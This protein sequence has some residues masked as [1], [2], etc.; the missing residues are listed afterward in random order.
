MSLLTREQVADRLK[1]SPK[2]VTRYYQDGKIPQPVYL[3]YED[4]RSCRWVESEL[5]EYFESL[6][7]KRMG[8]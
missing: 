5:E 2:T 3:N 6:K 4:I 7:R 1:V 8:A